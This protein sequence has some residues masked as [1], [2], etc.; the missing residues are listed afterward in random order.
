MTPKQRFIA[1][2]SRKKAD[3]LPVTTHHVMSFF[4]KKYMNGISNDEFFDSFGLDPIRWVMAYTPDTSKGEYFDPDHV[5]GFLEARRVSSDC[6][7]ITQTRLSDPQYETIRYDFVTPKKT[8]STVLQSN[9]HTSWVAERA[10]LGDR[11]HIHWLG[12]SHL[13]ENVR[14]KH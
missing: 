1:A 9:E 13:F 3:R 5:P 2:L 4:L 11:S 14:E 6:W 12:L 7:R 8:L 10:S